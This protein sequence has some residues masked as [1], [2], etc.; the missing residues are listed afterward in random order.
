ML[1]YTL[2]MVENATANVIPEAKVFVMGSNSLPGVMLTFVLMK[3][4]STTLFTLI[5]RRT[6]A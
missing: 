2:D 4:R 6:N 3:T 1:D 5:V